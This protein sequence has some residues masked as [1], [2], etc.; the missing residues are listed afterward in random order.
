M[1]GALIP[2]DNLALIDVRSLAR[3]TSKS[4]SCSLR[5]QP[6][7]TGTFLLRNRAKWRWGR[8]APGLRCWRGEGPPDGAGGLPKW[9]RRGPGVKSL[10]IRG[11]VGAPVLDRRSVGVPPALCAARYGLGSLL[12]RRDPGRH[13]ER[14]SRGRDPQFLLVDHYRSLIEGALRPSRSAS[15]ACARAEFVEVP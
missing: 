10:Q 9:R 1:D 7:G 5:N 8:G 13:V 14:R 2:A 15:F 4:V 6:N 12:G 11:R 3:P